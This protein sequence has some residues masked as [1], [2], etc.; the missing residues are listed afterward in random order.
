MCAT[1]GCS[2]E[3]DHHHEHPAPAHARAKDHDHAH[4]PRADEHDHPPPERRRTIQIERDVLAKND[5]FAQQNRAWL[6]R[7]FVTALNLV[8]SPGAGKT[9]ILEQTIRALQGRLTI[10]VLEGDQETERDAARIR[11]TGA[12]AIQINTGTACHLDA[13]TVGHA[14][15]GLAPPPGSM[16]M[17]ENV[18]NLVCPA[19]FDLGERAKVVILSVT[20]GDDKPLKYPHMFRA[21]EVMVIS[22]LDLLPHVSF[23]LGRCIKNARAVQPRMRIFTLSATAGEGLDP[24]LAW[25]LQATPVLHGTESASA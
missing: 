3:H 25:L 21:S 6:A 5:G 11:A 20:E 1:C 15:V 10:S 22:K 2:A 9:T 18:G 8:S 17:I 16:V 23:D 12:R 13:H 24:W 19:M 4:E 7:R 14:L